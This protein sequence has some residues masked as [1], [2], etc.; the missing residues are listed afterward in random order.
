MKNSLKREIPEQLLARL[1]LQAHQTAEALKDSRPYQERQLNNNKLMPDLAAAIRA[2]GLK[3]GMTISF[4][5][6]FRGG[7][8]LVNTVVEQLAQMGYR[9]LKLAASSLS[10]V[11]APLIKQI[12]NGVISRIETSGLRGKLA[13]AVSHGLMAEPVIF[14]SHGGRASAIAN[15]SLH[16]DVAFLGAA[17]ADALGNASGYY[18][19]AEGKSICGSLGYALVDACYADQVVV[20]TD[21]LVPYPNTPFSIPATEV[22]YVVPVAAVGDS[23]KISSG[24]TRYTTNPRD[25]LIAETAAKVIMASGYFRDGFSLQTG[26]GGAALAVT[27]FIS[28]EMLARGIKAGFALGGITGQMVKL[29]QDGLIEKLLDVQS[30]D[31]DAARSLRD[32]PEHTEVDACHY[33]SPFNEGS[34]VHQL[35]VV[36]LSA[37]EVDTQFNVNVLTGSDG[38]IRGAIGGHPD[39]AAGAALTVLVTPLIRGRIPC[40]VERVGCLITEG[41]DCDVLV[42]DMGIAVN[43]RRPEV[44]ERLQAAGIKLKSI[45]ALK[46]EAEAVVGKPGG[47]ALG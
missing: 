15:G 8:F 1:G 23:S 17:S 31:V 6:H 22:D 44:A 2:T 34:A 3:N 26:S 24:A 7:D 36:I 43:P 27:R 42:T 25:L 47:A 19:N 9:D 16:I 32:N 14:R 41:K 13:D 45:Q 12:Q 39:T 18:H 37:L 29:H 20:I 38:I 28:D 21:N 40:V 10:D 46:D 33:A 11:H 4:H 35:D 30:F 5:H